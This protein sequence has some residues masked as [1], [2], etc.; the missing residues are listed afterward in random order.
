VSHRI[1]GTDTD[2]LT[3]NHSVLLWQTCAYGVDLTESVTLRQRL[4]PAYDAM[5]GFLH[6]RLLPYLT[7]EERQLPAAR[8]RDERMLPL[9]LADHERLRADVENIASC[10]TRGVLALATGVLVDRLDR[11][12]RREE[13]WVKPIDTRQQAAPPAD[14]ALPL[15]LEDE[16]NVD[17][18]PAEQRDRLLRQRLGWMRPGQAVYLES[19]HDLH[20]VW[21]CQHRCSP[22]SHVWVYEQSGPALWRARITR[23]D[24]AEC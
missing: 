6:Y 19:A 21:Q 23:R 18:F 10:H 15:L 20:E 7:V 9:L 8:L 17:G 16:I 5:L 24:P 1:A 3:D 4:T 12:L 13:R 2:L 11:H 14:W 22:H